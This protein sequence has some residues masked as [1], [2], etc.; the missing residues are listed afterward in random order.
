MLEKLYSNKTEK[1]LKSFLN[2]YAAILIVSI[3]LPILFSTIGYFISGK[4]HLTSFKLLIVVIP[5][6][7]Y[8]AVYLKKR[9]KINNKF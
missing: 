3:V 5:W 6:S 4:I 7:L 9:V 1:E 8:N 2:I